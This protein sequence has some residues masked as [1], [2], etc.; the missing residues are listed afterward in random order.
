MSGANSWPVFSW[1]RKQ[2]NQP[3]QGCFPHDTI[4]RIRLSFH[5]GKC[6]LGATVCTCGSGSRP[7]LKLDPGSGSSTVTTLQLEVNSGG[8]SSGGASWAR[9]GPKET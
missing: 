5:I 2:V 9:E 1:D 4:L 3:S 6:A 8:A 7:A